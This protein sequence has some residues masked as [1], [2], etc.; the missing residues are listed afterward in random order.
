MAPCDIT[1]LEL[2]PQT[3][4]FH[5]SYDRFQKLPSTTLLE[6]LKEGNRLI[7]DHGLFIH[8]MDFS[9]PF[10]HADADLSP[11]NFLQY[12]DQEWDRYVGNRPMY[13]NRLRVDDVEELYQRCGLEI[14][15]LEADVD[16]DVLKALEANQIL[17]S[18]RFRDK[19]PTALATLT[20]W[21]IS[22]K[23]HEVSLPTGSV[24]QRGQDASHEG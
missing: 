7:K 15:K 14:V 18:T 13:T 5:L 1:R 19:S 23:R 4:D 21:V 3:V 9:D 22:C 6:V 20:S 8:R 16:A 17:L 12:T 2:L 24:V 10:S 11:L